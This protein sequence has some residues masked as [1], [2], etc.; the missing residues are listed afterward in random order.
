M[1]RSLHSLTDSQGYLIGK[2]FN[3]E[4]GLEQCETRCLKQ[5]YKKRKQWAQGKTAAGKIINEWLRQIIQAVTV[6]PLVLLLLRIT[7]T[8]G[9]TQTN[10]GEEEELR[11]GSKRNL[12]VIY[13]QTS[14]HK[15][16]LRKQ[17]MERHG[18]LR[19]TMETRGNL[20]DRDILTIMMARPH[21]II[22][23]WSHSGKTQNFGGG[24]GWGQEGSGFLSCTEFTFYLL[25]CVSQSEPQG[26]QTCPPKKKWT[27]P[28]GQRT[29]LYGNPDTDFALKMQVG[30]GHTGQIMK[31]VSRG[32]YL[33]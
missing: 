3:K 20:A 26:K 6:G 7:H 29:I 19:K 23:Y 8:Q 32:A 30:P 1:L 14:P 9:H 11:S 28:N 4:P 2:W 10:K 12:I 21:C 31:L 25:G 13:Q 18:S 27:E 5:K 24:R 33:L 15:N 22:K 17:N 16:V